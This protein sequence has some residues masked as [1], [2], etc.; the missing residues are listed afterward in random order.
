MPGQQV[1]LKQP[2]RLVQD[3]QI[4]CWLAE[5]FNMSLFSNGNALHTLLL[6]I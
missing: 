2:E 1:A 4:P 3:A 6:R 5:G